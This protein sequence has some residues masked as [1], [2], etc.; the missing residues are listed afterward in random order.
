MIFKGQNAGRY[1]FLPVCG[2]SKNFMHGLFLHL[3]D[4]DTMQCCIQSLYL[5]V[6]Q[7]YWNAFQLLI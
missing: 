3:M 4:N 1:K 2:S 7:M 5:S 6:H